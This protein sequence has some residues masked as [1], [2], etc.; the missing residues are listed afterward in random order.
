MNKIAPI[1]AFKDNYIWAIY[2]VKDSE[3]VVVDPGDASAVLTFLTKNQLSLNAILITHHHWDH[4]GG[5]ATLIKHFPN[6]PI[7]GPTG[8]VKEITHPLSDGDSVHLEAQQLDL[9]V[10]AI[11]GHTLDHI[12]YWGQ[13]LLFCGDT[14]FSA[15]SGRVFEGT[16]DQMFA[17]LNKL[18]SLP[19]DTLVYCGHEYTLNN[20]HFTQMLEPDNALVTDYIKKT[21]Q[22]L[23]S[24]KPSLPSSIGVEKKINPFFRCESPKLQ[25][26][27]Q[28]KIQKVSI[29]PLECYA[30]IRKM[31]DEF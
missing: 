20:L 23:Q 17:S 1:P 25:K 31:K 27:I 26:I 16:I 30:A 12:A 15:G 18:A 22:R 19:D 28:T 6:I 7:Y 29:T 2:S 13:N 4:T 5:L 8:S 3:V 24:G 11:P 14:L 10:L 9:T 21:T